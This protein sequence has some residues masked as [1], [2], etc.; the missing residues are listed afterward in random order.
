MSLDP[1]FDA[2]RVTSDW[3]VIVGNKLPAK[4][5]AAIAAFDAAEYAEPPAGIALDT[6]TAKNA[7]QKITELAQ[8]LVLGE[9]FNEAQR[10]VILNLAR[11]VLHEAGWAVPELVERVTPEFDAAVAE[12]Q[13]AVNAL[14]PDHSAAALIAAG[15]DAVNAYHRAVGA[16]Q[17]LDQF[18]SWIGSMYQLPAYAGRRENELHLV[19]P[20]NRAELSLLLN[21]KSTKGSELNPVYL[22]AIE[23]GLRWELHTPD[24]ARQI[25]DQINAQPVER[26]SSMRF[27]KW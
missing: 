24:E 14:P 13:A 1:S 12:F 17:R 9:K 10:H 4:L 19:T 26:N 7:E 3:G 18:N 8:S 2:R 20:T 11:T 22:T 23:A 21:A 27:V 15:G 6:I 16:Q 25:A 5:S